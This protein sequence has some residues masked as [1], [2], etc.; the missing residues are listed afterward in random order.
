MTSTDLVIAD[1]F[2][3]EEAEDFA[4]T[5]AEEMGEEAELPFPRIKVPSSG[6][7]VW[8]IPGDDPDNPD[9]AKDLV[10]VIVAQRSIGKLFLD[11]YDSREEGDSGFPD[12]YSPDGKVQII[13]PGTLE[14]CEER[15]L[16]AP[17]TS[18][19][20]CPYWQFGSAAL[21]GG[22]GAGKAVNQYQEVYLH[23]G[24]ENVLP[25]R[26][27][28]PAGSLKNWRAF[29]GPTVIIRH[30]R[31]T[32]VVVG[33]SLK[34]ER[35]PAGKDYSVVQFRVVERLPDTLQA[36]FYEFGRGIKAVVDQDG[37]ARRITEG[38]VDDALEAEVVP[39]AS[40]PAADNRTDALDAAFEAAVADPTP[41][42]PVAVAATT[43]GTDDVDVD[44]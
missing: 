12:A 32:N 36:K 2:A 6:S 21:L 8:E 27:L 14:K 3:L 20:T 4:A 37:F 15:G 9:T 10:G 25:H 17:H 42:E 26:I 29:A 44:F 19:A 5:W 40:A 18:T 24:G 22:R 7:T 39:A 34:K 35:N 33:L 16:P 13:A 23:L 30:K 43:T 1:Q 31:F 28:V 11:D 38:L 41:A